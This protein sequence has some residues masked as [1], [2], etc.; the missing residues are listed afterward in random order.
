MMDNWQHI[1]RLVEAGAGI[2]MD[3][4]KVQA[5]DIFCAVPGVHTDGAQFIPHALAQG[6]AG[7]VVGPKARDAVPAGVPYAVVE[8]PL[9]ALGE[10][11]RLAWGKAGYPA[12]VGVTGTNGKTTTTYLVEAL[13][14]R[15]GRRPGVMGTV[16]CRWPGEEQPATM[17]TPDPITLHRILGRMAADGV[18]CVVLEVSSHALQQRRLAGL[19]VEVGV[20]TNL[21][22][23][24]LDYHGTMD[25]YFAA[26][27][28]LFLDP[29]S[30]CRRA[31]V[32]AD[33]PWG[34]KLLAAR[35]DALTFG[36]Q[37]T[38]DLRGCVRT[39][40]L[41]GMDLELHWNGRTHSLH[42]PL[43]GMFNASNILAAIGVA[44]AL[45]L[46]PAAWDA[47]E[48]AVGAPGRLQ[49][50]PHPRG[51]HV[52][53]DYAHTPDAL[54]KV[55]ATLRALEPGRLLVVFGC[56]GDRD[57]GKRPLMGAAAARYAHVVVVTSDNPRSEDPEAIIDAIMP[58]LAGAP[59][60]VQEV[61]RRQAIARALAEARPGDAVLIAGKG[62][63]RVQILGNQTIPF[64]DV[65][66]AQEL[67]QC[68]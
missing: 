8:D 68:T 34:R 38:A 30:A 19:E 42:S 49:R 3:S 23:D 64:S 6:A 10:L 29:A 40:G 22:Q 14:Q 15:S 32:N 44:I 7:V 36:L 52:F 54:E 66:V 5:G 57:A 43:V 35:P 60:V 58:G 55:C 33:D 62:H 27:S 56:G 51:V 13:L 65:Q 45:D 9:A 37:E 63:E 2:Q 53:V 59:Q 48:T 50:I 1:L 41:A 11:A 25:A 17:T 21:T 47:L 26:K 4:R 18:D 67:A 31:V 16:A 20:F 24:H 46:P 39:M 61:D 28:R 12:L